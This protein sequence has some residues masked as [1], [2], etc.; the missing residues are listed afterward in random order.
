MKGG[1]AK[2]GK[3]VRELGGEYWSGKALGTLEWE[4]EKFGASA[5][6]GSHI[7]KEIRGCLQAF[8]C[9]VSVAIFHMLFKTVQ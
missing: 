1:I 4:K 9:V 7:K 5:L 3:E 6:C 8:L 2:E